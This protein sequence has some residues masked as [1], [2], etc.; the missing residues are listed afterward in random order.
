MTPTSLRRSSLA[1]AA[2][3]FLFAVAAVLAPRGAQA[4]T[5]AVYLPLDS[6]IYDELQTLNDMG[7]LESYVSEIKPISRVEAARLVLEAQALESER[8]EPNELADSILNALRLQLPEEIN[9][10]EQDHEDNLP[11]MIHPVES[12]ELQYINSQG[13]R[14]QLLGLDGGINYREGTPLLPYNDNLPTSQGSNEAALWSGWGGFGGFLTAYGEGAVAGPL[15]KDANYASRAQLL[16]G[17]VVMSFGNTAI[18]FGREEMSDGVGMFGVLSQ[19]NN[20]APFPALRMRNIHPGHLPFFFKY[21]GLVHYD[22]FVGQL[23]TLRAYS[24]P[25]IA[26]Q[27]VGFR[28]LPWLEWGVTHDITFGGSNNNNYNFLGFLGRMTGV[29]TGSSSSGNTNSRVSL[30]TKIYVPKLRYTQFYGEILGEDFFEPFG[31]SLPIKTPFKGPS[32]EAGIYCP[33]V[34][35][36][37]RTTAG[38]EWQLTDREYS[39]HSDSLYW[40]YDQVLMGNALGPGA[41]NFDVDAGRWLTVQSKL[42]LSLYYTYRVPPIVDASQIEAIQGF[43]N[44]NETSWGLAFDFLHLPVQFARAADTLGELRA[45]TAVEY[46][47]D[48]NYSTHTSVRALVQLSFGITPSWPSLTWH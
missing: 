33:E 37:G 42:D 48:I 10:V 36:D 34:T 47:D 21:L 16:T 15:N 39:T 46:V 19:S 43:A 31:K 22:A 5:Y 14:R 30:Y 12:V 18:S 7:L 27:A 1:T 26:G 35:K 45:R 11:T 28:T 9:W 17:A 20:A 8:Q 40:T 13:E 44:K 6:S 32:Y 3:A 29:D 24:S 4:S 38:V 2:L 23:D 41:W 25:W